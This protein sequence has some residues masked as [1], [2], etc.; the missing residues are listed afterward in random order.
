LS[1]E[2]PSWIRRAPIGEWHFRQ[3][4]TARISLIGSGSCQFGMLMVTSASNTVRSTVS[5]LAQSAHIYVLEC[6]KARQ[7]VFMSSKRVRV[8]RFGMPTALCAFATGVW[9]RSNAGMHNR[10][11]GYAAGHRFAVRG[12]PVRRTTVPADII[13]CEQLLSF[14]SL[15]HALMFQSTVPYV[16]FQFQKLHKQSGNTML[17]FI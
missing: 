10:T 9:L 4:T 11:P 17:L 15:V 14:P 13:F 3:I 8:T 16:P 6:V 1:A 7:S 5:K 12:S 2:D